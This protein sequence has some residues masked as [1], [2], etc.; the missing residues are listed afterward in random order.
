MSE[1]TEQRH[2]EV[3]ARSDNMLPFIRSGGR[4]ISYARQEKVFELDGSSNPEPLFLSYAVCD[5][6]DALDEIERLQAKLK[7]AVVVAPELNTLTS[8]RLYLEVQQNA[9]EGRTYPSHFMWQ[10]G[11]RPK[12]A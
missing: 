1:W 6:P 5:L 7:G 10:G 3:R 12:E 8:A 9:N 4:A 2:A 11:Q